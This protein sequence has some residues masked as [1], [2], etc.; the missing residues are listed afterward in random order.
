MRT[1]PPTF[2]Y[3]PQLPG[4]EGEDLVMSNFL[5]PIGG[6]WL[7]NGPPVDNQRRWLFEP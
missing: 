7:L 3:R 4:L 5:S 2:C 1:H 6:S